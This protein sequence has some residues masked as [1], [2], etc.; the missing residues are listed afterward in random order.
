MALTAADLELTHDITY[1]ISVITY[2]HEV[3]AVHI[4]SDMCNYMP[5]VGLEGHQTHIQFVT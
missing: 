4:S 3:G 5:S 1:V 2:P